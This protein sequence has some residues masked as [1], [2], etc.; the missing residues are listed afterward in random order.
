MKKTFLLKTLLL[1]CALVVE[2][3][4][5]AWADT[6]YKLTKV[7]SVSAGNKYVFEQGGYVMNNTVSSSA[8]QC[9]NSYK[10]TGLTGTESYVWTLETA[11]NGFYMKNVSLNSSQY[12][13]NSSSTS[14]SFGSASSQWTFSFSNEVAT[15][16]N[17]S[18]S[19]RFLGFTSSTSH[20]YK[21]YATSNLGSSSY[22]HAITVYRLDEE[23]AVTSLSVKSAPTKTRYEIGEKL[24]MSG[25]ILDADGTDVSSGYTMTMDDSAIANNATLNSAGKK[26]IT[27]AYGGKEVTQ[28]ISVGAVTSIAVTTAPTKTSYD[29]GDSFDATGMVVTATLS[30]G[31]VSE[32]DTW[33]KPVTGY[34]IDPEENLAPANTSV[35][36]T[37][38]TKTTTQ[39]ITV[40][41]VAVTGVSLKASTTI[42]KTKTETLIPTFTPSNATNKTV[43]WYSD[44]ELVAT[45][46]DAGVVTAVAAGTANVTVTTNDGGK[47]ATC[48]VTVVNAKGGIDAP[49]TVAEVIAMNPGTS[50]VKTDVYVKG[51]I[52]GSCN[53]S[54]G[55]IIVSGSNTDN[56]MALVDDPND[57]TDHICVQ[58]SSGT[59]RT[60]FNVV[61]HPYYVGAIQVLI[62]ADVIKYCGIPGLKNVDEIAAVAENL[63][64]T[65]AGYAT[66]VSDFGLNCSGLDIKAY[67]AT[68]SGNDISF[69]KVTEVPAGEGVLLQGEGTYVVPVASVSAWADADNAFVRGT[70]A[71]VATGTGPY[72][73]ILNKKNGV[74]GFYQ[75][76]GQTVAKN[77]A[78]LQSVTNNARISL[79]LNDEVV[80]RID[81]LVP[82]ISKGGGSVYDLMGRKVMKPAKG[83]Y[84]VNGKK[85]IVK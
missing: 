64:V 26:T 33:T 77:R 48:I 46:S 11:T 60:N 44:D 79:E 25:F 69:D 52:A 71:A 65:S 57:V 41:N 82:A 73:Y 20:A 35:T 70:G 39:A 28:N 8:L 43:S 12:L 54:T 6:T 51:Y 15:I 14:V 40:T 34:T 2:G 5:S 29:T 13:N 55:A 4:T 49:Y 59:N 66:Y 1:L 78:Y 30:T 3:T 22:P 16:Q 38:A 58:L 75:A 72:N 67:K 84:I 62:K 80:A 23:A 18:N 32:P 83:L 81:N 10:T 19:N 53:T 63:T 36:I 56:N 21:A 27:V 7:T 47:T 37:Y 45:V 76:A 9:T 42:E 61:S 85:V 24:D 17:Y 74:V 68:V 50:A 31:E